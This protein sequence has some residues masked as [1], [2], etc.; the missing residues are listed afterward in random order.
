MFITDHLRAFDQPLTHFSQTMEFVAVLEPSQD[1][2]GK[3]FGAL[4][5]RL[6]N[7]EHNA[8]E[9][10]R[11]ISAEEQA[12]VKQAIQKLVKEVRDQIKETA[13]VATSD[14]DDIQELAHLFAAEAGDEQK[15]GSETDPERF[16]YGQAQKR[17]N[18][19]KKAPL[20]NEPGDQGG[21]GTSGRTSETSDGGGSGKGT[22]SG[23][24]GKGTKG[25]RRRISLS[26]T[27][28]CDAPA[29][30]QFAHEV[31]FT[32]D[33]SGRAELTIAASGLT[34]A[35]ELP[36]AKASA[37]ALDNGKIQLELEKGKRLS[38]RVDLPEAYHGPMEISAIALSEEASAS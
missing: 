13:K 23:V 7:P 22:G 24:G 9:P 14:S 35:S 17:R 19:T 33:E 31:Y 16:T 4:L 27:R 2:D 36:V 34:T 38:I 1:K 15:E 20:G 29:S 12:R 6:E 5:K 32:P 8:F 37:G 21:S 10:S 3:K 26:A 11:I 18:R 25:Q 28:V 30:Q